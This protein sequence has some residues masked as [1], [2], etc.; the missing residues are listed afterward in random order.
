MRVAECLVSEKFK[1]ELFDLI[2]IFFDIKISTSEDIII[3]ISKCFA[4]I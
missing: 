3:K 2:F 4:G 1:F